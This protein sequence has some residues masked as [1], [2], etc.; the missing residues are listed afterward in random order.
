MEVEDSWLKGYRTHHAEDCVEWRLFDGSCRFGIN[1]LL[2]QNILTPATNDPFNRDNATKA[3]LMSLAGLRHVTHSDMRYAP[4][5]YACNLGLQVMRVIVEN[6]SARTI[7]EAYWEET[8]AQLALPETDIGPTFVAPQVA[9]DYDR[10]TIQVVAL[11]AGK[12]HF[13]FTVEVP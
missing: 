3:L 10:V 12:Q 13:G 11:F 2:F 9:D 1:L 5:F 7:Y 4:P 6:P 8:R